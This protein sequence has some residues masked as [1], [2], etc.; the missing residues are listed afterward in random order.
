MC[1]YDSCD[2]TWHYTANFDEDE[3]RWI[4][5]DYLC[6]ARRAFARLVNSMLDAT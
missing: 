3:R 2:G 4:A 5:V 6:P 1:T